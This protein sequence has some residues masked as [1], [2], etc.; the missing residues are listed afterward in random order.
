MSGQESPKTPMPAQLLAAAVPDATTYRR[1]IRADVSTVD[2]LCVL[3]V[4]IV[5]SDGANADEG[6]APGVDVAGIYEPPHEA[7]CG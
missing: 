5:L 3:I 6:L 2:R 4:H 7:Y 1:H